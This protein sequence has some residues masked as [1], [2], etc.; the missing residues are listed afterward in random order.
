VRLDDPAHVRAQY[1]TEHGLAARKSIYEGGA[2]GIDAHQVV[3]AA[4]AEVDPRRV[5]E[6]G[7]GE[8][9][10]AA[11]LVEELG[12]EL[13]AIDQS[14]RMVKL[15]RARGVDARVGDV[16]APGFD[17]ASFDVVVAAWVLFHVPRLD[18]ALGEM[19]RVLA[20]GG[21]LVAATNHADHLAEMYD[22]V[23][24]EPVP[25][26]FGAENGG[27]QLRAYFARVER[28]D[29]DGTVTF[30][31]AEPI[32]RYLGSSE[33]LARYAERVPELSRPLVARRRP[34]VFVADR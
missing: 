34:V 26:P 15:A 21:R 31:T 28:R 10:L 11:R 23:G 9:E 13:V 29:A 2:A 12:V 30:A 25:L 16:Q 14:A 33:R 18:T 17:D 19:S 20:P 6:V 4:V 22:L 5:L 24:A 1:E 32:R 7:C 8:G 3:L 27:E